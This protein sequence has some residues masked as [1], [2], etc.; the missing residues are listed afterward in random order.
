MKVECSIEKVKAAVAAAE[1]MTGKNLTLPILSSILLVA[2]DSALILRATNLSL[3]IE[4][5]IPAKIEKEGVLAIRGDILNNLFGT[6]S[7]SGSV[8]FEQIGDTLK[9]STKQNT[10][11]LKT[12]PYDDFPTIPTIEGDTFVLPA[13]KLIEGLKSVYYSSSLSDIKPEIA[14]IYLYPEG[15][16]LV[17]VATDSFRLAE[18]KIKLKNVPEFNGI[19]LP[20]KNAIEIIK[21]FGD[22]SDDVTVTF[23]KNQLSLVQNGIYITSRLVDGVFPDYR[24]ILPKESKTEAIVLKQDLLSALKIS[25]IFSDKFNQITLKIAPKQKLFEIF[26]K[27]TDIGEN[28]TVVEA[29]LSGNEIEATLNFKYFFDCFQSISQDSVSISFTEATKPVVI[30]GVSDNT[31]TYL[32]MPMNR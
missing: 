3:G 8:F 20:Y 5:E 18:K 23:T 10:L 12:Y 16:S 15:D 9:V 17:F 1:R 30:R 14:S 26:S 7:T 2:G 31:F 32:I 11:T 28:K 25:N 4:I 19:L 27:N 21:L 24:Q 29:A 6:L 22:S 13:K